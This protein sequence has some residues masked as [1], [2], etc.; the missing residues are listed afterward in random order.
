M[1]NIIFFNVEKIYE[2]DTGFVKAY[3]GCSNYDTGLFVL[4][5]EAR[6]SRRGGEW[7]VSLPREA[8]PAERKEIPLAIKKYFD[9][10][11]DQNFSKP[12]FKL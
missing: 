12:Y 6:R 1:D 3:L 7:L 5:T 2:D 10:I 11:V 8:S 9:G 4:K